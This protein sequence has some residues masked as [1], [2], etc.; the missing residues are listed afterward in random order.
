MGVL[1]RL[2]AGAPSQ[3]HDKCRRLYYDEH[4]GNERDRDQDGDEVRRVRTAAE[5]RERSLTEFDRS[6]LS[7]TKV[8]A[9]QA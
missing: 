1:S 5:W 4:D 3:G 6:D 7:G 8:T 2:Q 9:L